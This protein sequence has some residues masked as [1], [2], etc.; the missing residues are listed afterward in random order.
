[1][2]LLTALLFGVATFGSYAQKH[3]IVR[4][5]PNPVPTAPT[6]KPSGKYYSSA[7]LVAV[8]LGLSVKWASCNL[9]A[10]RPEQSGNYYSHADG[11]TDIAQAKL[12]KG[13]RM[14]RKSEIK[15]M[16]SKCKRKWTTL[17]GI[18]GIKVTGPNGNSIFIPASGYR[19]YFLGSGQ[20][21]CYGTWGYCWASTTSGEGSWNLEFQSSGWEVDYR[22]H[23]YHIPVRP[24]LPK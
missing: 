19:D 5:G 13:W 23:N 3:K 1:M 20:L 14:P 8:D 15:E 24:V 17:N 21:K 18:K 7:G 22:D 6:K 16:V 2:I 12:G 4:R 11:D 10:S 9:G